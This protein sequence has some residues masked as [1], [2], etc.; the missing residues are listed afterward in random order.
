MNAAH[1]LRNVAVPANRQMRAES[2]LK[3]IRRNIFPFNRAVLFIQK[4]R[5]MVVPVNLMEW[6]VA[7]N[8]FFPFVPPIHDRAHQTSVRRLFD[9]CEALLPAAFSFR[10]ARALAQPDMRLTESRLK[11][12]FRGSYIDGRSVMILRAGYDSLAPEF[13]VSPNRAIAQDDGGYGNDGP[14]DDEEELHESILSRASCARSRR[15]VLLHRNKAT[16][17]QYAMP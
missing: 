7:K 6:R 16:A 14:N 17:K 2:L 4:C 1:R 5:R 12:R 8:A 15:K 11:G 13:K 10:P 9:L 3:I